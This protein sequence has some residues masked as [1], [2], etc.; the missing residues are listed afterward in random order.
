MSTGAAIF[1][2]IF[3]GFSATNKVTV[4]MAIHDGSSDQLIWSYDHEV[5]GGLG[6]AAEGLAKSLWQAFPK[7]FRTTVRTSSSYLVA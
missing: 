4:N 3:V 2:T 7:Y 5:S 6:S 1:P